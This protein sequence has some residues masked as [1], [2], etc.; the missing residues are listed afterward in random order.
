VKW[1][2]KRWEEKQR[3]EKPDQQEVGE[4]IIIIMTSPDAGKKTAKTPSPHYAYTSST[5]CSWAAS[6]LVH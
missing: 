3:K 6:A 5:S 4:F 2:K 1:A